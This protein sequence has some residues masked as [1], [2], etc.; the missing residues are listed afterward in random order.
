MKW[1]A[2]VAAV[3]ACMS[4]Q[5]ANPPGI[6]QSGSLTWEQVRF[7]G[8]SGGADA[9]YTGGQPTRIGSV[10]TDYCGGS[11]ICGEPMSF[12]TQ[13]GG[14][15]TVTGGDDGNGAKN[16]TNGIVIQDLSPSYGGLGVMS[17]NESTGALSGGDEINHGDTLTLT[18]ANTVKIVG[19]HLWD[20]NHQASD[21]NAGDTFS[22]S[23]NGG[24]A[25]V[26]SLSNFPWYGAG[27][28]LIGN[29]FTFGYT[30]EDYYLGAIKI[31]AVP[32][33]PEPQTYALMLG[34]LGAVM[35][36]ARRRRSVVVSE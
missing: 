12:T 32:A 21:L 16:N 6:G 27:S 30:N 26:L 29:T 33:V 22:L 23:V 9:T 36:M 2:V 19:F 17:R 18:F 10:A 28:A 5:A 20:K 4:A 15:L 3:G 11:D 8:P 34:G 14:A 7:Y 24:A 35:F 25:Q 1:S 13:F 31:A